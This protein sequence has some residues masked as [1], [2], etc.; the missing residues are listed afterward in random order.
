MLM[1]KIFNAECESL[2]GVIQLLNVGQADKIISEA[3]SEYDGMSSIMPYID[4]PSHSMAEA[5]FIYCSY[6]AIYVSLRA[7]GI[8]A[9]TWGKAIYSTPSAESLAEDTSHRF[10]DDAEKSLSQANANEFVFEFVPGDDTSNEWGMNVKSC[11][12]CI[13]FT[14]Y[15]AMDLL[16]YMC[17]GD[18]IES[19]SNNQGLR[20]NGTIGLGA[21]ECDF[22]Y[23][24]GGT[25]QPL[26]PQFP[27]KIR[28]V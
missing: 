9:H 4:D 25:P 19:E 6:L 8:D 17:A 18:D 20:R 23:K 15:S 13:I 21:H 10:I 26:A 3:K 27:D 28:F 22:K 24:V 12:L 2:R 14:K 7:R 1:Q 11:A 16:P 5:T